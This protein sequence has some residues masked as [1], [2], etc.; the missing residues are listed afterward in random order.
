MACQSKLKHLSLSMIDDQQTLPNFAEA[1]TRFASL[2]SLHL[3]KV[4]Y[5]KMN[6]VIFLSYINHSNLRILSLDS[7]NFTDGQFKTFL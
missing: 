7:I 5:S 3:S 2:R 1:L 4:Q 6:Q